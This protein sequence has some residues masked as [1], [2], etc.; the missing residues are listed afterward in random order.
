MIAGVAGGCTAALAVTGIG[1]AICGSVTAVAGGIS[2][3]TG[4]A[5]TGYGYQSPG[6]LALD[7][8]SNVNWACPD[9]T[10]RFAMPRERC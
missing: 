6:A 2:L 5:L 1:A 3:G 4:I 8:A 7:V 9:L 10:D